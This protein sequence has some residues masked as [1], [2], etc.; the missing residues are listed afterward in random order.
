MKT[1]A[2]LSW[3][4][5]TAHFLPGCKTEVHLDWTLNLNSFTSTTQVQWDC[6]RG[7]SH[8]SY[9][10]TLEK[11]GGKLILSVSERLEF[12]LWYYLDFSKNS[13]A[14]HNISERR[15]EFV[16]LSYYLH[17]DIPTEVSQ[18]DFTYL[19]L[20]KQFTLLPV[21][22]PGWNRGTYNQNC[23]LLTLLANESVCDLSEITNYHFKCRG[24]F[25]ALPSYSQSLSPLKITP[26]LPVETRRIERLSTVER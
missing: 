23:V 13:Q 19:P 10:F 4:A 24:F 8:G 9:N 3:A 7:R 25:S 17:S 26:S 12:T 15:I 11:N 6:G 2:V 16:F 14:W 22:N 18:I 21:D 1:A 20:T 5:R